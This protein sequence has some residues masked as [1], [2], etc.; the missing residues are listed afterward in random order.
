VVLKK[1]RHDVGS[2][3]KLWACC[4]QDPLFFINTFCWTYDNRPAAKKRFGNARIPMITF[5]MQD[6]AIQLIM[7]GII[8]GSDVLV[9]KSRDEGASWICI[10][11]MYHQWLFRDGV[12][13]L[14]VS[15]NEE[16]VDKRDNK[17]SLFWK[18]DYLTSNLPA[19]MRPVVNRTHMHMENCMNGSTFDGE[20]TTGDVGSGD[21]RT[22]VMLDEFAKVPRTDGYAVLSSTADVAECRI[23][24]STP[25]G[26]GT[27]HHSMVENPACK[28]VYLHWSRDP[29]KNAG[30]YRVLDNGK[31]E[32]LDRKWHSKHK[33]YNFTIKRPRC[34]VPRYAGLRSPWY[35]REDVRRNS[36]VELAQELDMN[37]LGA[38]GRFFDQDMLDPIRIRDCKAP[39]WEGRPED[40][41]RPGPGSPVGYG[42]KKIG[43][44]MRMWSHLDEGMRPNQNDRYIIAVDIS[45]GTGASDSAITITSVNER[46]DIAEYVSNLILPEDLADLAVALAKHF[47]TPKG[48]AY[49][50][51]DGNGPGLAFA[52]R[53]IDRRQYHNVYYYVPKDT[54]KIKKAKNPGVPTNRKLKYEMFV[55]LRY[56]L[57]TDRYTIRSK[58][59]FY[60]LG[61]YIYGDGNDSVHHTGSDGDDPSGNKDNHG[62]LGFTKG[63]VSLMLDDA[64]TPTR[65][66]EIRNPHSA[67]ARLEEHYRRLQAN[68]NLVWVK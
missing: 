15:R 35:D 22:A 52:R 54:F 18:L 61:C 17:K 1:A 5:E 31:I 6:E 45:T 34:P 2:Q 21:R 4:S 66:V 10:L 24:N 68:K 16:Y 47:S 57:S 51:W 53:V 23:F 3:R 38:G 55:N 12:D 36:A 49:L 14:L 7:D 19:W 62:D 27:A 13:F 59:A 26:A 48:D 25:K 56:L 43:S 64:H 58:E 40:I 46:A 20:S 44:T 39:I 11:A 37:H 33:D 8:N 42:D 60:Q 32:V 65:N 63:I 30:L 50:G 28:K 9:D 41:V 67:G 29:R